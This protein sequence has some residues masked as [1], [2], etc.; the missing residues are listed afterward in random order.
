MPLR[1]DLLT[2]IPG[3]DPAGPYLRYDPLYDK[4]KDA[5]RD[6]PLMDPPVRADWRQVAD[7]TSEALAK[8]TKDLQ[9]AA[10]L[11]EAQL[12]R[13][14]YAGLREG[15]ELIAALLDQFWETV[16]PIIEDG[17]ADMRA[18]PLGWVGSY[19]DIPVRLAPVT[20]KGHSFAAYRESRAI[21]TDEEAKADDEKRQRREEALADG[22]QDPDEFDAAFAAT[23]KAWYRQLLADVDAS[24]ALVKTLESVGDEKFGE[25]APSYKSL[26]DALAEVR[27]GAVALLKRKLELEP[28]PIDAEPVSLDEPG[29]AE[30]QAGEGGGLSV[31]PRS[32]DDAASRIA[33]AARYL[34]RAKPTDPAPYLLVRGFRWGEL[35]ADGDS[36][37]P[38]LLAAPPTEIRTRLKGMLLDGRW[39]DLLDAAEEVM[40]TPFGRGWLDLQRYVLT[41]T[42]ALGAE[43][44]AVT[45]SIRGALR[46]LLRD[47]PMLMDATLMD[48]SQTANA[49]TRAWLRAQGVVGGA[50]D[51][52]DAGA[53]SV[54]APAAT[55]RALASLRTTQP[56]RAIEMLLRAASQEK[57][58]RARFM[59]RSDAADIMV[60]NGLEP[61]AMPILQ[62]LVE[63]IEKHGLEDWES[64]DTVARP[65]GLLWQCMTKLD[66]D[67]DTRQALYLRVC[68]LDPLQAMKFVDTRETAGDDDSGA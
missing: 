53:L 44:G 8:R 38:R 60:A 58:E 23:P 35:R 34:R 9:L 68:R 43:Y 50:D 33:G 19:L 17:D 10:W 27:V 12:N 22:K 47:L 59:R 4:I 15:L 54:A 62:E 20:A 3:D 66:H 51:E 32:R 56:Q 26:R 13:E 64:G 31:E 42:E 28:D 6:D 45:T 48:D 11:T 41:A 7:L 57:S 46:A 29:E 39:A 37:N 63:L 36:P 16:H 24:V 65:L 25:S 49:E 30:A 1:D 55:D 21:P 67:Y 52:D 5:R 61:V 18:A 40:A 14:G 2:P